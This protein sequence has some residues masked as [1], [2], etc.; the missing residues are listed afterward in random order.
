[1]E[2]LTFI[3]GRGLDGHLRMSRKMPFIPLP[4]VDPNGGGRVGR[5]LEGDDMS[6]RWKRGSCS[7]NGSS[8]TY[9]EGP[10]PRCERAPTGKVPWT[11]S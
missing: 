11:S 7:M 6:N 5:P 2:K 4:L 8:P 1:M 10:M 3:R 9:Q